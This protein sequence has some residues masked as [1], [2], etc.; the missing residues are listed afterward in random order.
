MAALL[1]G[2]DRRGIDEQRDDVAKQ[3]VVAAEQHHAGAAR[4]RDAN[5][6]VYLE[7]AAAFPVL[8]RD[9]DLDEI[10]VALLLVRIEQRV[11]RDILDKDLRP[12]VGKRLLEQML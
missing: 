1:L 8:L 4:D 11:R 6:V 2:Q 12:P 9:E 3:I 10:A 7:T 5:F